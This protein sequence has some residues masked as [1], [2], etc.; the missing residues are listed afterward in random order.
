MF[1]GMIMDIVLYYS[2]TS[3]CSLRV[4]WVFDYKGI[5][6]KLVDVSAVDSDHVF[7]S[8]SPYGYV[9]IVT[10]DDEVLSES[11]AIAEFA[12]DSFGEPTLFPGNSLNRARIR[13]VCEFVNSTIHPAQNSSILRFLNP[14]LSDAERVELRINWINHCLDRLKPRL[15]RVSQFAVGTNFSLADIFL[16]EICVKLVSLGGEL[17]SDYAQYCGFIESSGFRTGS[18]R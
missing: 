16:F 13:E 5:D 7:F 17:S 2:P 11:M 10:V 8:L 1:S 14:G 18:K 3:I 6:Y 4:K 12:E 15:W 9:P